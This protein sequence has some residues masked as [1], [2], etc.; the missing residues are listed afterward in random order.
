M[1]RRIVNNSLLDSKP[2]LNILVNG[3]FRV[4]NQGVDFNNPPSATEV[5]DGWL[6]YKAGGTPPTVDVA[7]STTNFENGPYAIG[8]QCTAGGSGL[9]DGVSIF[10]PLYNI[11]KRPMNKYLSVTVRLKTST[12]N[13][14]RA[15]INI[16]GTV[17]YSSYHTGSGNYE[18]LTASI[19]IN[20]ATNGIG[21]AVG[22]LQTGDV[23]VSFAFVDSVIVK[24]G[25]SPADGVLEGYNLTVSKAS[26]KDLLTYRRPDLEWVSI[27]EIGVAPNTY[28]LSATEIVVMFPDGEMRRVLGSDTNLRRMNITETAA[29]TGTLN[30]GLRSG[31]S[32]AA[33]TWYAIYA[34]K[35]LDNDGKFVLV[36]DTTPPSISNYATLNTRYGENAW[37]FLGYVRNGMNVFGGSGQDLDLLRF[38]QHAG[39]T[40]FVTSVGS[41]YPMGTTLAGN[42]TGT[43][44]YTPT[45]GMGTTDLPDT[46]GHVKWGTQISGTGSGLGFSITG[47]VLPTNGFL[48]ED[49]GKTSVAYMGVEVWYPKTYGLELKNTITQAMT[50]NCAGFIDLALV[51]QACAL[52]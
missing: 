19:L 2:D 49:S 37:V 18:T 1:G 52:R 25:T 38:N 30:S 3:S 32:E 16:G 42:T 46:I 24:I 36:G 41:R 48:F 7:R 5:A 34:W 27:T 21:V 9:T 51:G 47:G 43:L 17:S 35:S 31:I 28:R 4:W 8:I 6:L 10:Q 33:N 20:H 14:W 15:S 11:E 29:N 50:I 40:I 44:N 13:K 12:A 26:L 39:V 45:T 23:A 22:M